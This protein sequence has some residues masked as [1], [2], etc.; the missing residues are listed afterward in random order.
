LYFDGKY[1]S[2]RLAGW[3]IKINSFFNYESTDGVVL[4]WKI[5]EIS[6]SKVLSR[7]KNILDANIKE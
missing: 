1:G 5:I 6:A 2:V 3:L 4:G 7:L